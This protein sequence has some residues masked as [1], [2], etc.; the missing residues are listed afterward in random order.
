MY[1]YMYISPSIIIP[2]QLTALQALLILAVMKLGTIQYSGYVSGG[3][4]FVDI[5]NFV[6][7]WKNFVVEHSLNHTP[8]TREVQNG[9]LFEELKL[10]YE[11][12]TNIKRSGKLELT[13]NSNGKEKL[14][15][16]TI[17]SPLRCAR[18]H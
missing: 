4:I 9:Q 8:C 10:W 7:S 14:V 2:H 6:G 15:T 18:V 11:T 17:S 3:K 5:E 1:M 13:N 12:T 16:P